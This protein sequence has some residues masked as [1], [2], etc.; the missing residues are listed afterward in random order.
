IRAFHVTGVQTCA[1]P[2]SGTGSG[3]SLCYFIPIVNAVLKERRTD[4]RP[5]TRAI[6]IYPMNALANSQLK[7]LEKFIDKVPGERP[8]SFAR[9]SEERRVGGCGGS[10]AGP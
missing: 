1:L 3:K 6:I 2:I 9:R 4:P 7:E 8:V 10:G 5:R